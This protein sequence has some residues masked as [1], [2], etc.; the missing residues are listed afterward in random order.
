M[1]FEPTVPLGYNGFRDRHN[2][3]SSATSPENPADKMSDQLILIFLIYQ[4][5]KIFKYFIMSFSRTLERI[6]RL[7]SI[8][9]IC[10]GSIFKHIFDST[11]LAESQ[12]PNP[13]PRKHSMSRQFLFH[14]THHTLGGKR[15]TTLYTF[16][17]LFL[18]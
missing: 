2:K 16:K 4:M 18:I 7:R 5:I 8:F 3:P 15:L 10:L 6:E 13:V 17:R 11:I 1:G 9:F 14:S 12:T